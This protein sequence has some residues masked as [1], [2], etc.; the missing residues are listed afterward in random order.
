MELGDRLTLQFMKQMFSHPRGRAHLLSMASDAESSGE[1]KVF[2]ELL[3]RKDD[4]ELGRLVVRH[5]DDEVRHAEILAER[6][7]ANAIAAGVEVPHVPEH[8]KL[9]NRLD[10]AL[11]GFFEKKLE[12]DLD[13]MRAYLVL[14]VIE[15][16]AIT[17]FDLYVEAM[18]DVDPIT[19]DIFK[20][21]SKD[22]SRHLRYCHAIAKRYAPSAE[23]HA[24]ELMNI[25]KVEA[26]VFAEN[27]NDN[28]DYALE[29]GLLPVSWAQRAAWRVIGT[30]AGSLRVSR[31]TAYAELPP[32]AQLIPAEA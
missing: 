9:I 12:T 14:Q 16:R 10:A 23:V 3:K 8:L 21:I 32:G 19:A 22:E 13:V 5:R 7:K 2:E 26:R 18:K 30:I 29:N 20:E 15:E 17:Q 1:G 24:A 4:V 27:S 28:L 25:R 6:A 31:W 11:G